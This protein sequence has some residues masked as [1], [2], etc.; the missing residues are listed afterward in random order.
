[1]K[2]WV[3]TAGTY[4][5]MLILGRV[6]AAFFNYHKFN[7]MT[8]IPDEIVLARIMTALDLE[9][10]KAL[11]HHD[12]GYES[13][14]DYG[15]PTQVTRPVCVYSVSTTEASLKLTDYK[16]AQCPISPFMPR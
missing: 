8:H 11:H 1:M 4:R 5:A 10:E 7:E 6:H 15:I 2:F 12:K 14:N 9:F 3:C 16:G 13:D